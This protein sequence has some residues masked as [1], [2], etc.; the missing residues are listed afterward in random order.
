MPS[1]DQ[2]YI[3]RLNRQYNKGLFV[4][5]VVFTESVDPLVK[6][7]WVDHAQPI[8][9]Q[10]NAYEPLRMLWQNIKASTA[11]NLEGAELTVSNLA[12][13]AEDY[14]E[15]IDIKGAEVVVQL[16]HLSLL[17]T[18]VNFY[19]RR[20]YVQA[21]RADVRAITFTI[22]R[23]LGWQESEFD[24]TWGI[25]EQ[26]YYNEL[27]EGHNGDEPRD[28]CDLLVSERREG[29]DYL[30][31]ILAEGRASFISAGN[32]WRYVVDRPRNPV[33]LV[34]EPKNVIENSVV[35]EPLQP[36]PN[37]NHMF[38]EYRDI[39]NRDI[40]NIVKLADTGWQEG[41]PIVSDA[42]K[43]QTIRRE[44][45][46]DREAMYQRKKQALVRRRWQAQG[47]QQFLYAEP[48][49][50]VYFYY[51]TSSHLRG[52]SGSVRAGGDASNVVLDRAVEL[53]AGETYQIVVQHESGT[54]ETRTIDT[55]AGKRVQ[56]HVTSPFS[57]APA[58]KDSYS[59]DKVD[60]T[61]RTAV[62]DNLEYSDEEPIRLSLSDYVPEVY[63]ADPLPPKS[64]RRFFDLQRMAPLPLRAASV[65]EESTI[66][67]DGSQISTL[68]FDVT[69][70]F[71]NVAGVIQVVTGGVTFLD[72]AE[73]VLS[74]YYVGWTIEITE[75]TGAG[76][77]RKITAYGGARDA[78]VD[79]PWSPEPV[80]GS[81]YK[82]F[83]ERFGELTGFR[84]QILGEV[85]HDAALQYWTTEP[86]LAGLPFPGA[87]EAWLHFDIHGRFQG[88][89]W[90]NADDY[91]TEL[92]SFSGVRGE[93][94]ERVQA[95]LQYFK[96]TPISNGVENKLGRF[97]KS[98]VVVGDQGAPAAPQSVTLAAHLKQVS[99]DIFQARPTAEDLAGFDVEFYLWDGVQLHHL[100]TV[101]VPVLQDST[102]SATPMLRRHTENFSE[103]N[104]GEQIWARA[105]A[106]DRTNNFSGFT[107]TSNM[108]TLTQVLQ[109]DIQEGALTDFAEFANDANLDKNTVT[110]EVEMASVVLATTGRP[111]LLF[112]KAT[113]KNLDTPGATVT[114][115]LRRGATYAG[116][117]LID[118]VHKALD[119]SEE[120]VLVLQRVH[121]PAPGT[122][123]FKVWITEPAAS[124]TWRSSFRRLLALEIKDKDSA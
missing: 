71:N 91:W 106:Y 116:S 110:T 28:L 36:D 87:S 31:T 17:N 75:G 4:R 23:E 120:D 96:F 2:S 9:F 88:H 111:I 79:S 32:K 66:A 26:A 58:A 44:S 124:V 118:A 105:R 22:G 64:V 3:D 7:Y 42:I 61:L 121:W 81:R 123:T 103:R 83:K 80:P 86:A 30:Q 15:T 51:P 90:P 95:G 114:L 77:K 113:L 25:T 60:P 122:H 108:I 49:Q 46:A 72:P 82:L 43:L 73:P 115:E 93:Y 35:S 52:W 50:R 6:K 74:A 38:A 94:H 19:E 57:A 27:V 16:L 119:P 76:Q 70:G 40:P 98:V 92:A 67:R 13:K 47:T 12:R 99:I 56:V 100:R 24:D 69:P 68:I 14:V 1:F 102:I 37:V 29:L 34:S 55:A 89:S 62:L 109:G 18:L 11:L 107:N 59:L 39:D 5:A 104:Y 20:F 117:V 45:Q 84:V 101:K 10:G 54:V 8:T 48:M 21:V 97:A 85:S 63:T 53:E 33:M 65:V 112:S 41:D 78:V